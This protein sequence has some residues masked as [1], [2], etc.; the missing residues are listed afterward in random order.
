MSDLFN[1]EI[2]VTV[3]EVEISSKYQ[4]FLPP[5]RVIFNVEKTNQPEPH[6]A[7]LEIWNLSDDTRSKFRTEK[8]PVRL[9]AGY[10]DESSL[11]FSGD[12][13]YASTI[14]QGVNWV[15][16]FQAGDGEQAIRSARI[17]ENAKGPVKLRAV[18][19]QVAKSL[20]VGLGNLTK[21][22]DAGGFRKQ[23][24]ELSNGAVLSGKSSKILDDML[25][26]AG[27]EWHIENGELVV[28]S[29]QET[30]Q[31]TAIVLSIENGLIG[32]PEVG[33]KGIVKAISLLQA[34]LYPTRKVELI[35]DAV[36]GH[37]KVIRV[38]H[39]GDTW[40]TD[41]YSELEAKPL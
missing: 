31:E 21:K 26:T 30:S 36:G 27:F 7:K 38:V 13:S 18:I 40:S 39:S 9:D 20:G 33:E 25:K 5:L 19:K 29:P 34:G 4:E 37:F 8:I 15:T 1:R 2:T 32:S 10:R 23:I 22:L 11:I 3:G 24:D 12:M 28:T 41:W 17:N 16:S 35:A 6:T 14:R